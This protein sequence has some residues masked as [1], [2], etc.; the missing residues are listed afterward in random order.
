MMQSKTRKLVITALFIAIGM[1]LPFLIGQIPEIGKRLSPMHIPILLCGFI[2]GWPYG[3]AAGFILPLLRSFVFQM[4]IL[5]PNAI[6]M[7]FEL[8]AY[9]AFAGI[10]YKALPKKVV[11]IYVSLI[12]AMLI[13]RIVWGLVSYP[14]YMLGGNAFTFEMFLAAA[15]VDAIPGII[16]HI[17]LIPL[18]VIAL[19]RAR[20]M[21]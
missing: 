5:Y 15:F 17:V 12:G 4:P 14:L 10:L 6:G 11:F 16:L 20:L 7:A 2:C 13:G 21:D 19:R 9:G 1:V 8:A 3:L 18:I